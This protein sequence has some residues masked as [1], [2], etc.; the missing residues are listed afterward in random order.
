ML[1]L[2]KLLPQNFIS[3]GCKSCQCH[4]HKLKHKRT[5]ELINRG[6]CLSSTVSRYNNYDIY[7]V[8]YSPFSLTGTKTKAVPTT[9]EE[10]KPKRSRSTEGLASKSASIESPFEA[11]AK[12]SVETGT[13]K[14]TATLAAGDGESGVQRAQKA[15]HF[16]QKTSANTA[17]TKSTETKEEAKKDTKKKIIAPSDS[18]P[19][20]PSNAKENKKKFGPSGTTTVT[21][22]AE[23]TSSGEGAK[24]S[25][26][27]SKVSSSVRGKR[28]SPPAS[29][30]L[31]GDSKKKKKHSLFGGGKGRSRSESPER[32]PKSSKKTSA[33][34]PVGSHP[35]EA[36]TSL[37]SLDRESAGV[38][39]EGHV[40]GAT[41]VLDMIKQY[42]KKDEVAKNQT[43]RT[44]H[45]KM[46]ATSPSDDSQQ[47]KGSKGKAE[48]A[49]KEASGGKGGKGQKEKEK[50]KASKD[51][52][53]KEGKEGSSSRGLLSFFKRG[54]GHDDGET[55]GGKQHKK[56]TK[57][58][59]EKESKQTGGVES[60]SRSAERGEEPH[61]FTIKGRIERLK[62]SGV[63]T[64]GSEDTDSPVVLVSVT[65]HED[66]ETGNSFSAVEE[67]E[68]EDCG[69][70]DDGGEGE[71]GGGEGEGDGERVE[72]DFGVEEEEDVFNKKE[73][74]SE[75]KESEVAKG[76]EGEE[77]ESDQTLES[78]DRVK[79]LQGI[80]Q[81]QVYRGIH[82]VV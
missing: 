80:F 27:N 45:E 36:A 1:E 20:L 44:G 12:E 78:V 47:G 76:G 75:E 23:H 46:D 77:E 53:K 29:P 28:A 67:E 57:K 68:E 11:S 39:G 26:K 43:R 70:T 3:A 42:D 21:A 74:L 51:D 48:S 34:D 9:Q 55:S 69:S 24:K 18:K 81:A 71:G 56:K 50:E 37:K 41:N 5:Y 14:S 22:V 66:S 73:G 4:P 65:K 35:L 38:A 25:S 40:S 79:R 15:R 61:L 13:A 32:T 62:E 64:D 31:H 58:E 54:K 72:I 8:F 63:Y 19:P 10:S 2:R 33:K 6:I 17:V 49:K 82:M 16:F 7:F 30:E 59:K 60:S 52:K